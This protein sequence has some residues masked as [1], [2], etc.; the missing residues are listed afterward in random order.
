MSRTKRRSKPAKRATGRPARRRAGMT[1]ACVV[2]IT[3]TAG[4]AFAAG[5]VMAPVLAMLHMG[6]SVAVAHP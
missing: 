3:A 2:V 6:G 4:A 5:P 1:F